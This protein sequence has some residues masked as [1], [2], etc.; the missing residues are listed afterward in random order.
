MI[1]VDT[2]YLWE[3]LNMI[4]LSNATYASGLGMNAILRFQTYCHSAGLSL[5]TFPLVLHLKIG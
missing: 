4:I 2:S 5:P 3:E 1:D